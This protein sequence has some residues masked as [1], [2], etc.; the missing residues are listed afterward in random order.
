MSTL[1]ATP[2]LDERAFR[3][4]REFMYRVAGIT[5]GEQK[6]PLVTGRL[7]RRLTATG[8]DDYASYIALV[9][10]GDRPDETQHAIDL[11]TTNETHFFREAAHFDAL[12]QFLSTRAANSP[13]L[14]VWSAACSSGE[15]PY[16][17]A[18]VLADH[19]GEHAS[20]E[21]MASDLSQ[22]MLATAR[23]A[24]YPDAR[25]PEI[26]PAF[27]KRFCLKGVGSQQGHFLIDAPLRTRVSFR[28]LNLNQ[29]L[30]DIGV[31]DVIFL[32]N[33]MIYFD[34]NTKR[35]VVTRLA[36]HLRPGGWL[37]VGHAESLQ[38]LHAQLQA[39]RPTIYRKLT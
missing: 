8:C 20:W 14:R 33:V 25:L 18:M 24:R 11:L 29:A 9:T 30:P 37:I 6:R 32:R 2:A 4:I 36:Q 31:F 19:L 22:R 13:P 35:E 26:P 27:L 1:P 28:Q 34:Q 21:V 7:A 10:S 39:V 16:T 3:H 15:E 23:A 12:R 38:G 5:L 17:I